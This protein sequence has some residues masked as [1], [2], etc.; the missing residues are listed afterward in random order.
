MF[1]KPIRTPRRR[2]VA[3]LLVTAAVA[4]GSLATAAPASAG[5]GGGYGDAW[6]NNYG[7]GYADNWTDTYHQDYGKPWG[8][9]V[10]AKKQLADVRVTAS[11]PAHIDHDQEQLWTV[12]ITNS[13]SATAQQVRATA[14]LPNGIEHRAHRISAGSADA[15]LVDGRIV[16]T[17]GPLEPGRSVT[18]Q[19]A[20]RGPSYGGGNVQFDV[21]ATTPTPESVTTNNTATVRTRIA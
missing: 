12:E 9:G 2:G 21:V 3:A 7:G 19:I 13:G 1:S 18:L 6:V 8:G 11:G 17:T 5:Y 10:P 15:Q 16:V 4:G 20:G 14:D